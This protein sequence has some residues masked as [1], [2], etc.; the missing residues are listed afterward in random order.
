MTARNLLIHAFVVTSTLAAAARLQAQGFE[1]SPETRTMMSATAVLQSF[2]NFKAQSIPQSMLADAQAI[3]IIP[4]VVKGGFVIAGRFGR[5][6]VMVKNPDGVWRAPIFVTFTG[7]S[8]GWQAG[9]QSTDIV[10]VFKNR[11]GIETMLSGREF[12]LGADASVA[13]GPVGRQTSAGTDVKLNAEVYSYSAARGL[14]LGVALDGSVLKVDNRADA[15]FYGNPPTLPPSGAQLMALVAQDTAAPP[16]GPAGPPPGQPGA[17]PTSPPPGYTLPDTPNN[18]RPVLVGAYLHME[19]LLD[20]NW[21]SFLALPPELA[22]GTDPS[23]E[24]LAQTQAKYDRVMQTPSYAPLTQRAEFRSTQDLLVRYVRAVDSARAAAR[25]GIDNLPPP[26]PLEGLAQ[27]AAPGAVV[28]SPINPSPGLTVPGSPSGV[29]P[30]AV[31]PV[32]APQVPVAP[33]QPALPTQPAAP[34]P[35]APVPATTPAQPPAPA[36][37]AAPSARITAPK[38]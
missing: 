34:Q 35:T 11:K 2:T 7:G 31:A 9:L 24:A 38:R 19:P 6:V 22:K 32:P 16:A 10:L 23:A 28:G 18:L 13:A 12:T 8:V 33:G 21:K 25:T 3:A 26:P 17:P 37:P 30:G 5:G 4:N 29:A 36:L 1:P 15:V 20:A 14:F 27:P